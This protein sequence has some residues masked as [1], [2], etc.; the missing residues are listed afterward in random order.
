MCAINQWT[1]HTDAVHQSFLS[2]DSAANSYTGSATYAMGSEVRSGS[3]PGK[4]AEWSFAEE[5]KS[6][7]MNRMDG[8]ALGCREP[9]PNLSAY[10]RWPAEDWRG[11]SRAPSR[12]ALV[13]SELGAPASRARCK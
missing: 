7:V 8:G 11:A 5:S 2:S 10:L 12:A 4:R 9:D 6:I 3:W 1:V 13:S